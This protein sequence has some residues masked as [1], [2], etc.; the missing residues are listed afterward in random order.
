MKKGFGFIEK[1]D[2]G[3]VFVHYSA[4]QASG[5]RTLKEGQMVEFE[6]KSGD[7]GDQAV[8]VRDAI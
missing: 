7:K 1:V 4:I 3:D 8:D 2:G 6:V 5:F